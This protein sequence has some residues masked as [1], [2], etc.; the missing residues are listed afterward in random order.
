MF[1]QARTGN[2]EIYRAVAILKRAESQ[3]FGNGCSVA[4][5]QTDVK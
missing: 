5:N 2:S 1:V 3:E 4:G